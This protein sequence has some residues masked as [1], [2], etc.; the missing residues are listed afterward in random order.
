MCEDKDVCTLDRLSEGESGVL[1]ASDERCALHG[2]LTDLG[3][4]PGTPIR[5]VRVSPLG[6]P[7]AYMV[8]GSVIALRRADACRFKVRI[9]GGV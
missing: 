7:V 3:W 4:I 5:C 6:D 1:Y 8:R 2:R 9:G